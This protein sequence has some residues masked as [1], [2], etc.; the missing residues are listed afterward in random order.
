VFE[1]RAMWHRQGMQYAVSLNLIRQKRLHETASAVAGC[2]AAYQRF[3]TDALQI[4]ASDTGD[5]LQAA[6][7]KIDKLRQENTA[8]QL[9][10][11]DTSARLEQES[12]AHYYP[13]PGMSPLSPRS[14]IVVL[15][16][17]SPTVTRA[18]TP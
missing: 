13:D 12:V 9:A 18:L 14:L 7:Q 16:P 17:A 11:V 10:A 8:L 6:V 1:P 3:F 2:F 4:Q 15:L 5:I